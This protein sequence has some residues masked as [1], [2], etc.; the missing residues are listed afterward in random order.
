MVFSLGLPVSMLDYV[1]EDLVDRVDFAKST[2]RKNQQRHSGRDGQQR[3]RLRVA[4]PPQHRRVDADK[5]HQEAL[6]PKQDQELAG[7]HACCQRMLNR[8]RPAP[9]DVPVDQH[10]GKELIK[11]RRVDPAIRRRAPLRTGQG[12]GHQSVR[13]SHAPG[14]MR[15]PAVITVAGDQAADASHG[16]THRR[17]GAAN[18]QHGELAYAIAPRQRQQCDDPGHKAAEPREP[19]AKPA[20]QRAKASEYFSVQA[21]SR[22]V[23]HVPQLRPQNARQ[24]HH[25]NYAVCVHRQLAALDLPLQG[26]ISGGKSQQHQQAEGR[27]LQPAKMN[28]RKQCACPR[29]NVRDSINCQLP[30]SPELPKSPKL[31]KS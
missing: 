10:P 24:R 30:K 12:G 16:I 27:Q 7:N 15:G 26:E 31:P 17:R 13:K 4:H 28:I 21:V 25:R 20:Q 8:A 29:R 1:V 11:R 23:R 9:P 3:C 18:I 22:R 14:K 6:Q 2:P 5:F 19:A